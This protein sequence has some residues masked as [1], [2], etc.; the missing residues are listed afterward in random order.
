V[1][2]SAACAFESPAA[3]VFT[4]LM[5]GALVPLGVEWFELRMRVDDPGGAISVHCLC[6][7]WGL[8]A[9]GVFSTRPGDSGQLTAQ[10]VG[11]ATLAGFVLPLTYF[12]N[13]A[14]HSVFPQR[15]AVDGEHQGMDLYELGAGAYPEFYINEETR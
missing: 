3:A 11:I 8:L 1:A 7:L 2:S 12:L 10:I 5:A 6:G 9:A 15:V 4:G 13:W 14:L